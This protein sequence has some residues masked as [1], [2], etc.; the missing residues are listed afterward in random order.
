[1][2]QKSYGGNCRIYDAANVHDPWHNL[3]DKMDAFVL[4]HFFGFWAKVC[5]LLT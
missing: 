3:G 4:V 2:A 5:G 1:M